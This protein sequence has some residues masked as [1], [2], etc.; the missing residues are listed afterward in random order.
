VNSWWGTFEQWLGSLQVS[1]AVIPIDGDPISTTGRMRK[2]LRDVRDRTSR[3]D[4]R[5]RSVVLA[6]ISG[7]DRALILVQHAGIN[8]DEF[9]RC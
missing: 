9:G 4:H 3:R 2:G 7:Q 8:F 1:L 6:G 5:W